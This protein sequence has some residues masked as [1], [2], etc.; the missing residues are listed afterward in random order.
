M[1][2]QQF[3]FAVNRQLQKQALFMLPAAGIGGILGGITAPTGHVSGMDDVTIRAESIA[4]GAAK[5]GGTGIGLTA[6]A[7]LAGL[8]TRGK[9]RVPIEALTAAGRRARTARKSI[10]YPRGIKA[11][12]L[13]QLIFEQKVLPRVGGTAAGGTVGYGTASAILGPPTWET[14]K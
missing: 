8:A 1:T 12:R 2:P 5:G 7:L 3:G 4:R 14:K 13:R 11:D 6:G 10:P 9:L